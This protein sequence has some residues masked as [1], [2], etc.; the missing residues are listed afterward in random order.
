MRLAT[1]LAVDEANAAGGIDGH[2]L[3]VVYADTRTDPAQAVQLAQQLVE[4][5]HVD[6]LIGGITSPECL[7]VA[8]LAAKLGVVY[9]ASTGCAAEELTSKSC[10]KYVF[11]FTPVGRQQ[12]EPLASYLVKTFGKRWAM[13]YPDYAYGQSQLAAYQAGI[14]KA[15]GT[16]T[17]KI[18][19]PLGEANVTPY[20]T[21]VPTDGS[22][23]G[24]V[25]SFGGAD[26]HGLWAV[27]SS[28]A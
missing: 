11:R 17:I 8:Q 7:G 12:I 21:K 15:G 2:P 3:Q 6:V 13:L 19:V 1:D 10:N 18:P 9:V 27:S 24:A 26:Q 28:L 22:I 23:D 14:E 5:D 4:Q 20:V 25:A 16:L